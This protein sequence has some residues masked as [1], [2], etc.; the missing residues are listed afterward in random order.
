MVYQDVPCTEKD[1]VDVVTEYA[2]QLRGG[3]SVAS[4]VAAVRAKVLPL[5]EAL[6][7]SAAALFLHA[8]RGGCVVMG[9]ADMKYE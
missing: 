9:A 8:A 1:Q 2:E 7:Q 6:K 5:D 4:S 3:A